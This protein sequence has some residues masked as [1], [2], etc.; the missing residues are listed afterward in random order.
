MRRADSVS[1]HR[2]TLSGAARFGALLI[3]LLTA[4]VSADCQTRAAERTRR[5][6]V[7]FYSI[8]CGIDTQAKERLDKFIAAYEQA[9]GK[10]LAKQTGYWGKEGEMDYCF[11]LAEL[12]VRERSGFIAKVRRLL[13]SSTLVHVRE[14]APC[15]NER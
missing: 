9:Q 7:S 6:V 5:L 1:C 13:T 3:L 11:Q 8:C 14:N 10:R 15:K 12:T 2:I 4:H